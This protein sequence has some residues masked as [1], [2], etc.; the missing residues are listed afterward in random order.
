M[1]NVVG[2]SLCL[3]V[4]HMPEREQPA[5]NSPL[6]ELMKLFNRVHTL[7]VSIGTRT[8]SRV[9]GTVHGSDF[10]EL[11]ELGSGTVPNI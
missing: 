7:H 6:L 10:K 4:N 11:P 9:G 2:M 3:Q 1:P 8:V 5:M